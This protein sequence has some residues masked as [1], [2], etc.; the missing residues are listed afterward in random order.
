MS[1]KAHEQ[2]FAAIHA[3]YFVVES[4]MLI[5]RTRTANRELFVILPLIQIQPCHV[6]PFLLLQAC[7]TCPVP[8]Y[9]TITKTNKEQ[10]YE[11]TF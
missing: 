8:T 4:V 1:K 11:R 9:T 5:L 3:S 10:H 6:L 7:H 2:P